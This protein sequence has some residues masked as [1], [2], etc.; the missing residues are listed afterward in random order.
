MI[1]NARNKAGVMCYWDDQAN[2]SKVKSRL[3]K[4]EQVDLN[5][6]CAKLYPD[7]YEMMWHTVGEGK[8]DAFYGAMLKRRGKKDGVPDWLV[9]I[10][11]N[12]KPGM[13]LELKRS[14]KADSSIPKEEREFLLTAEKWGYTCIVAY[15]YLP[16]LEAIKKYLNK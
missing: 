7:E 15:G 8:R 3:E 2:A 11:T 14:R 13:F 10:P 1:V 9:M 16:A 6:F 12:G 4:C 5:H